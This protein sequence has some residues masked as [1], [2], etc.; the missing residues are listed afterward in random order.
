MILFDEV[1]KAHPEVF[2][3]FLQIFDDGRLTDTKGRTVDFKNTIII[4]TS[5]IGSHH[6]MND[7]ATGEEKERLVREDLH[8]QFK[9]EFLNR[10]DEV[11]FFEPIGMESL[12]QI[13]GIQVELLLARAREQ[14]LHVKVPEKILKSFAEQG[15][16]P[17]FGA[18]PLKRGD[19]TPTGESA[20]PGDSERRIRQRKRIYAGGRRGQTQAEGL[21]GSR[22]QSSDGC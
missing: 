17:Q 18:R 21:K 22:C 9:P 12:L 16:D 19:S 11:I 1:E 2:N 6:L 8:R 20:E 13:V 15:Y 7:E 4:M 14:G 10:L 3:V 5:N